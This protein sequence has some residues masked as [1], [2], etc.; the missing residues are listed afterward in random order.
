M[1]KQRK[2]RRG[3]DLENLLT[4][5]R[6]VRGKK[7]HDKKGE[8]LCIFSPLFTP[9]SYLLLF[10][11]LLISTLLGPINGWPHLFN[12]KYTSSWFWNIGKYALSF[13]PSQKVAQC[14]RLLPVE[15]QE[16]WDNG[17]RTGS[18]AIGKIRLL[19]FH[20][21]LGHF[22]N[23]F[24]RGHPTHKAEPHTNYNGIFILYLWNFFPL[25][26]WSASS[27]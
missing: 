13:S 23:L 7:T 27:N 9:I 2:P 3:K 26:S 1:T 17:I 14:L 11:M 15:S 4:E 6:G 10:W 12:W 5:K 16:T 24:K 21:P 18:C 19:S 22:G 20:M 25:R 8:I